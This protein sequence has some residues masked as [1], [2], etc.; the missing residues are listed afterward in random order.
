MKVACVFDFVSLYLFILGVF[1][2]RTISKHK[3]SLALWVGVPSKTVA[4]L[5]AVCIDIYHPCHFL[6]NSVLKIIATNPGHFLLSLIFPFIFF[7]IFVT[8]RHAHQRPFLLLLKLPFP[9][10]FAPSS[11]N[12]HQPPPQNSSPANF[13]HKQH[14]QTT[15]TSSSTYPNNSTT[16]KEVD[17][18][19]GPTNEQTKITTTT[20]TT[21]KK[22]SLSTK[23]GI[24]KINNFRVPKP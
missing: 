20:T 3:A 4:L 2:P 17:S 8:H 19:Y 7:I 10:H 9:L 14:E 11:R 22:S 24:R 13:S 16:E 12:H 15:R 5:V 1:I 23:G 18:N 6:F 21:T